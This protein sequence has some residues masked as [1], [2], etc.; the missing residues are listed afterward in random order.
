MILAGLM[1]F[2]QLKEQ[3]VTTEVLYQEAVKANIHKDKDAQ[4]MMHLTEREVMDRFLG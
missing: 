4:L 3:L 1:Q 2:A